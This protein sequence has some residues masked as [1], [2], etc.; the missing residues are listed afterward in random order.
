MMGIQDASNILIGCQDNK[1][2]SFDL[3]K[4]AIIQEVI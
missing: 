3:P 4:V 1:L 2:V